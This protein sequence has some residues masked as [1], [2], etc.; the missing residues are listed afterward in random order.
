MTKCG[1]CLLTGAYLLTGACLLTGDRG[2]LTG[3]VMQP[4][5]S[6]EFKGLIKHF[7]G[8]LKRTPGPRTVDRLR[9]LT[10]VDND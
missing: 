2:Q 3:C 1:A 8:C 7:P 4:T 5:Y 6:R 10:V 9:D